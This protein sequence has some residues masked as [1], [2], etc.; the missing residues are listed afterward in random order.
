MH[1]TTVSYPFTST[2]HHN[3]DRQ[4]QRVSAQN[5]AQAFRSMLRPLKDCPQWFCPM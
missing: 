3:G 5:N 1:K 4:L 2:V